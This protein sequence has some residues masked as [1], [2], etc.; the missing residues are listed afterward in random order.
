MSIL[1]F[2]IAYCFLGKENNIMKVARLPP[3]LMARL[4]PEYLT[5]LAGF[6]L[7]NC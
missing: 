7:K 1:F 4:R 2:P 3:E 5:Q 6:A